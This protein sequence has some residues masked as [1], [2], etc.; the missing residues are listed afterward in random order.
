M[1]LLH[2]VLLASIVVSG[3]KLLGYAVP[4]RWFVGS[5]R[6]RLLELSTISLLAALTTVQA[7]GS[8]QSLELDARAPALGVAALLLVVR[9]PFIVV[10]FVAAVVAAVLRRTGIMG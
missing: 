3:L 7:F 1:T 5:K 8:G 9:A 10:V 2:T 6:E 4:S